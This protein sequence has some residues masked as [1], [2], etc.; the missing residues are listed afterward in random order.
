MPPSRMCPVDDTKAL[1]ASLEAERSVLGAVLLDG[2]LYDTAAAVLHTGAHFH[3]LAHRFV[4]QAMTRLHH[5]RTPIDFGTVR[6]SLTSAGHLEDVGLPYLI[7]LIDGV[8]KASNVEHYAKVVRDKAT[9]RE[10]IAQAR[11]IVEEALEAPED[12]SALVDAAER[13][14]MGIGQDAARGDFLV[15][16]DWMAEMFGHVEKATTE[17]RAVTGIPTGIAELDRMTRGLQPSDLVFIGARPSVGKTSLMLQIALHAS[18]T[19]FAGVFSLE[20]SRQSVGFRA[21]AMEAQ[22]DAFRLMTGYVNVAEQRSVAAAMERLGA[23][24]LAIDDSSGQTAAGIRAKARRLASRYGAGVIFLDYIQLL[25]TGG[26]QENRN[27][28]LSQISASL[29]ALAKELVCPVVVLSQ[30]SRES[31]KG[32]NKRPQLWHLRDSGSLEQDADLVMLLH[33]P[34]QHDDGQRYQDGELA[35]LIVAKQRNGPV[36]VVPLQ[37]HATTMR[38]TDASQ[39]QER[40]A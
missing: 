13:R 5:A 17:R 34:S 26:R 24:R 32:A 27:Q 6:E 10:L 8:P 3:R 21:V 2:E 15:A 39:T 14:L 29:K 38:F 9:L 12:V 1:P 16:E 20:M 25:Y 30:L 33:R 40:R 19:S 23:R 7:A 4:W 28:E 22:V 36:G 11:A 18:H 31:D 37:W 35:E